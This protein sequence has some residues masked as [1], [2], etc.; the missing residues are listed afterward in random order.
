MIAALVYPHQL[1]ES[2]PAVIGSRIVVLVEDPLF[3]SQYNFHAQKLLLHRA[4]MTEFSAY[5]HRLG[6]QVH[7]IET[8]QL[9]DTCEIGAIL[10]N[11]KI[12]QALGI[13][14]TDVW[15]KE[16]VDHGCRTAKVAIQ[17]L[18]DPAFLTPTK[19]MQSWAENRQH[20][21]FTDFYREQRKRLGLLLDSKGKP[22]G[23]KWTFD[24]ENRKRLPRDIVV[25]AIPRPAVRASVVEAQQYVATNFPNAIG[26]GKKPLTMPLPTMTREFG[27]TISSDR[28]WLR[29]ETM[30]TRYQPKRWLCSIAC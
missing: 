7:R 2:N 30:K 19:V 6:K 3:F 26:R 12:S 15:L 16:R 20:F 21:H 23:G 24:T 1:W 17:W 18:E 8:H 10:K 22:L 28:G 27:L 11:L 14:P 4:S 29:L 13:D 5:C 25:P 9:V